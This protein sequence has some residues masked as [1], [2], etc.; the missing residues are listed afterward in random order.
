MF[1][2]L[3]KAYFYENLAPWER[4][5]LRCIETL[6]IGA[7]IAGLAAAMPLL[8][9]GDA[10]QINW[11]LVGQAALTAAL[12][13]LYQGVSKYLKAFGDPPLPVQPQE[14]DGPTGA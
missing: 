6:L 1:K 12:M 2:L 9:S 4:A 11:A 3:Q 10:S 7:V 13:A 5:V 8:A 14:P